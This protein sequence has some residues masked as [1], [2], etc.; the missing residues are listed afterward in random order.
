MA[1]KLER[2]FEYRVLLARAGLSTAERAQRDH[3][4]SHLPNVVPALDDRDPYTLLT[5]PLP[6]EVLD[7]DGIMPALLRNAA[8]AGFALSVSQPPAL[9]RLLAV[10]V[11]D[12]RHPIEYTF[13]ARVMSRVV[14][15]LRGISVAFEGM[16]LQSPLVNRG[17]GVWRAAMSQGRRHA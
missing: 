11:R 7:S 12:P 5:Q 2:I 15:G 17:S 6:A 16:P 4:A 14:R 8:A 1:D 3:L 9:G 13:P 10:R